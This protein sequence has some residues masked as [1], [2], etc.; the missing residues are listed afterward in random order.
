MKAKG[1]DLIAFFDDWPRGYTRE[2]MA[3]EVFDGRLHVQDRDGLPLD[4]VD[5]QKTY[6][7][8]CGVLVWDEDGP[9]PFGD[10][11]LFVD[12]LR[13]RMDAQPVR[14]LT[15]EVPTEQ[16]QDAMALFAQRGW[17]VK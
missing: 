10:E 14:T 13:A 17:S 8:D 1:S 11:V 2:D 16:V 3:F 5:P 9:S 15:V 6:E 7:V 12:F 4:L